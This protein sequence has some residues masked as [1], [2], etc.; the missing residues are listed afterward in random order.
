MSIEEAC[1]AILGDQAA[2]GIIT[3]QGIHW[4]VVAAMAAATTNDDPQALAAIR[5]HNA[6]NARHDG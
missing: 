5:R 3:E 4:A 6:E 2:H 1:H